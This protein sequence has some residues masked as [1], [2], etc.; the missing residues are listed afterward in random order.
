MHLAGAEVADLQ[1]ELA[2]DFITEVTEDTEKNRI[3]SVVLCALCAL[4]G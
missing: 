2:S 1:P 3:S 4:C